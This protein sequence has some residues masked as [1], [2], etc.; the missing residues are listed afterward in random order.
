LVVYGNRR[1]VDQTVDRELERRQERE[2]T[3]QT[4]ETDKTDETVDEETDES[5]SDEEAEKQK[6]HN[7]Q[8]RACAN[9]E[10]TISVYSDHLRNISKLMG[11]SGWTGAGR[12]WMAELDANMPEFGVH[13]H[14]RTRLGKRIFKSLTRLK[15]EL[16]EVPNAMD[17][18]EQYQYLAGHQEILNAAISEIDKEVRKVEG[19]RNTKQLP[20]RMVNDFSKCIIP[21]LVLVMQ[22]SFAVGVRQPDAVVNDSLP[23][24]GVFTWT[25]VQYLLGTLGWL[26]RLQ[27]CLNSPPGGNPADRADQQYDYEDPTQNREKLAVMVG[28]FIQQIRHEVDN[29]NARADVKREQYEEKQR[30]RKMKEQDRRIREQKE[31]EEE[32]ELALARQ[33][34]ERFRLSLQQVTNQS[35]PRPLAEKFR[36]ATS[37]WIHPAQSSQPRPQPSNASTWTLGH[38]GSRSQS[39]GSSMRRLPPGVGQMAPQSWPAPPSPELGY[40][41]WD[42]EETEWLLDELRRP[43]RQHDCLDVWVE[44]LER[45]PQEIMAEKRRL[46]RTGQYRSPVRQR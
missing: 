25:T 29:F 4:D 19:L 33:K 38:G 42:E 23:R 8:V 1:Q 36:K 10:D 24:E 34:E 41:P 28:K 11:R 14:V 18:A 21:M 40:P 12:R 13:S 31:R 35:R 27:K 26:S 5:G 3:E 44:T 30:I 16:D 45:T 7:I 20:K 46:E 15:D 37:H 6:M 9:D 32:E 39:V 22:T 43:D 17:L 2:A